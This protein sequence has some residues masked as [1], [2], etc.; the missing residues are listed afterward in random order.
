MSFLSKL[1]G[2]GSRETDSDSA[3]RFGR[4][5]LAEIKL[6]EPYK[7]ERGIK[8][9]DI[10]GSLGDEITTARTKF[11]K[12]FPQ[13]SALAIFNEEIVAVLADGDATLLGQDPEHKK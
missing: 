4:L 5:L 1:F 3:R 7:L 11:T 6:A 9:R 10:L 2:S 12:R 13:N 8:T